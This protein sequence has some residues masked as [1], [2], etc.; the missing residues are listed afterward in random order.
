MS[1]W[2]C[3]RSKVKAVQD[4]TL[5]SNLIPKKINLGKTKGKKEEEAHAHKNTHTAEDFEGLLTFGL[6]SQAHRD[7]AGPPF[8]EDTH[9]LANSSHRQLGIQMLL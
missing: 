3:Q 6:S 5:K 8:S 1:N 9:S 4:G 2:I 7:V